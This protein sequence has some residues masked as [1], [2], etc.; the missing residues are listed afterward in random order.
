VSKNTLLPDWDDLPS[1]CCEAMRKAA[2]WYVEDWHTGQC[3][4]DMYE[5]LRKTLPA[6]PFPL[7]QR[8]ATDSDELLARQEAGDNLRLIDHIADQIGLPKDQELS[9]SN[10]DAW[11][12]ARV[13]AIYSCPCGQGSEP[14]PSLDGHPL[15]VGDPSIPDD[16]RVVASTNSRCEGGK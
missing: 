5:E 9:Q 8:T 10:F 6:Q 15:C 12:N 7:F 3:A 4:H 13:A 2:S 1:E 11:A 16:Q 14:C